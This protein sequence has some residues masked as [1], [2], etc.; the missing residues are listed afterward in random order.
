M[1]EINKIVDD[2]PYISELQKTF[3]KHMLTKRK[4]LILDY[5]FKSLTSQK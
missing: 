4:E 5:S 1:K 2:T 3:Y